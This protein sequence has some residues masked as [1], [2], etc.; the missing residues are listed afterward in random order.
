MKNKKRGP[1]TVT[2]GSYSR[3]LVTVEVPKEIWDA[4]LSIYNIYRGRKVMK[5]WMKSL[6]QV[7]DQLT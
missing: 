2:I 6:K 5:A 3:K 4:E 1:R 7:V